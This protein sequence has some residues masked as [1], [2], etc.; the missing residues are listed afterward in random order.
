MAFLNLEDM[1]GFVEVILFPEV[2]KSASPCLRSGDP[3]LVKGSLDLSEDHVKVK[4][5]EVRSLAVLMSSLARSIHLKIPHGSLTRTGLAELKEAILAHKGTCRI[6]LHIT[7]GERQETVIAFSDEFRV[8][9][10]PVF[11][12]RVKTLFASPHLSF[13]WS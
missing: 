13:E 2:F 10:S 3:L 11:Q 6:F 8:D 5:T 12:S 9:P 7:N 1:K 4:A